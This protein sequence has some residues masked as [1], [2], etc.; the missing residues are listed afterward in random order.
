MR[1]VNVRII[2][3][4][5]DLRAPGTL[6]GQQC[7]SRDAA[8]EAHLLLDCDPQILHQMEPISHLTRLR[9]TLASS[10]RIKPA[11][12]AAHDLDGRVSLQ[13][14]H[15]TRR[16]SVVKDVDNRTALQVDDHRAVAP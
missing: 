8:G 2:L 16:A 14:L 6:I 11:S 7:S 9:G 13:P 10:L 1:C 4:E 15:G 5:I 3:N 12:V